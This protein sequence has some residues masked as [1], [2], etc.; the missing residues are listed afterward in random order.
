M[1]DRYD[2]RLAFTD[3]D[4]RA[5]CDLCCNGS[6]SVA[7]GHALSRCALGV[8]DPC[9]HVFGAF[10][11]DAP[12]G[13]VRLHVLREAQRDP[14][15]NCL[16]LERFESYHPDSMGILAGFSVLPHLQES[17]PL[18]G[19]LTRQA[20]CVAYLHRL[21]FVC[22]AFGAENLPV[23]TALGWRRYLP[24]GACPE[25][26]A[27]PMCFVL[28]DAEY[29]RQIQS[30]FAALAGSFGR[31]RMA[32]EFFRRMQVQHTPED[33]RPIRGQA[34]MLGAMPGAVARR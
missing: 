26:D 23:L 16:Q 13:V 31:N 32:T 3:R 2:I 10:E 14:V 25:L 33:L 22:G 20:L 9:S 12:V 8:D 15:M 5:L 19:A 30:P 34:E 11:Q 29:L 7:R 24:L 17:T 1:S 27:V 6:V 4:Q 21:E 18:L 28:S